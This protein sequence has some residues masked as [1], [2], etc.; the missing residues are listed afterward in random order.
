MEWVEGGL[1]GRRFYFW[2]LLL[3]FISLG[4]IIQL[5]RANAK[6][7]A[8]VEPGIIELSTTSEKGFL[9]E[10]IADKFVPKSK[11]HWVYFCISEQA[12]RRQSSKCFYGTKDE[13]KSVKKGMVLDGLQY[14]LKNRI[15]N[16]RGDIPLQ[17]NAYFYPVLIIRPQI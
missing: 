1:M 9:V 13:F 15:L 5:D 17:R 7:A 3:I 14:G 11:T 10:D 6:V 8:E 16:V 2:M 4:L 12:F